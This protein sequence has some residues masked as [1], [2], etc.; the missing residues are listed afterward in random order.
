LGAIEGSARDRYIMVNAHYDHLGVFMGETYPGAD[1]N[2]AAVAVVVETAR[3]LQERAA[4]LRRSVIVASFD[5]EEPPFFLSAEMG[6]VQFVRQPTVPLETIDLIVN[7]DLVGRP[8]GSRLLSS[9]LQETTFVFG[10]ESGSGLADIIHECADGVG[11]I[12][13]LRMAEVGGPDLSDHYAFRRAGVPWLF[14]TN[15]RDRMYHTPQD[16]AD[17]VDP[18]RLVGLTHHLADLIVGASQFDLRSGTDEPDYVTSIRGLRRLT[19]QL[20]EESPD[21]DR[22]LSVLDWLRESA[23]D[24]GSLT[25]RQRSALLAASFKLESLLA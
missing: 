19:S 12:A 1:D 6:S 15:G 8:V 21:R 18:H 9:D 23:V 5:A 4:E 16:T 11:G 13:P 14:Y 20:S 22:L 10:A 2:A 7:L 17:T 25:E 3:L 24:G